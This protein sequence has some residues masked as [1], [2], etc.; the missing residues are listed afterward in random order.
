MTNSLEGNHTVCY[1]NKTVVGS[2]RFNTEYGYAKS[3]G[4][5]YSQVEGKSYFPF[6][7]LLTHQKFGLQAS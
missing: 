6:T 7:L 2:V 3:Q 4:P 5:T 1:T